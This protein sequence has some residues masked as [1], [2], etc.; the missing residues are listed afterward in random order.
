MPCQNSFHWHIVFNVSGTLLM[1]VYLNHI[2]I[3][4]TEK[5]PD[6]KFAFYKFVQIPIH[7]FIINTSCTVCT[8]FIYLFKLFF[9]FKI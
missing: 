2:C 9:I 1:Y 6:I 3:V 8:F 5:G 7:N 4:C